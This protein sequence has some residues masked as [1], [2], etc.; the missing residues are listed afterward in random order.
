[1]NS[2]DQA[3]CYAVKTTGNRPGVFEN[4][5]MTIR[6]S[7]KTCAFRQAM[8]REPLTVRIRLI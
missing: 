2:A 6:Q 4:R 8:R 5:P 3:I 1:M 7:N